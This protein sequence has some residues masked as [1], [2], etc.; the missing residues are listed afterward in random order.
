MGSFFRKHISLNSDLNEEYVLAKS[1]V[2][3]KTSVGSFETTG[4]A[5]YGVQF[6]ILGMLRYDSIQDK[7]VS[8][9]F[10]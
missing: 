4:L 6:L 2:I 3:E 7:F 9:F 10:N 8:R 1:Y 5:I